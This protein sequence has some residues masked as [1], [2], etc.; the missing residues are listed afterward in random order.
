MPMTFDERAAAVQR[1]TI[2]CHESPR[3]YRVRVVAWILLGYLIIVS[4]LALSLAMSAGVIAGIVAA[5]G[6]ILLKFAWVPIVASWMLARALFVRIDAPIGRRLLPRE[7]P[8]LFAT[9]EEIRVQLGVRRLSG[10]L[11]VNDM[12]AAVVETPRFGGLFGWQRYLLLGAPLLLVQS[13]DE[14]RAILAHELGHLS[15]KHGRVAAWSWRVRVTWSRVLESLDQ[16]RGRLAR[17]LQRLIHWYFDHMMCITLVQ[18]RAQELA[19]DEFAVQMTDA[20][21]AARALARNSVAG[22]LLLQHFWQPLWERAN[23]EP[24]PPASPLSSFLVKRQEVLGQPSDAVFETELARTTAL[25]DTHPS[26]RE[27][28]QRM[29]VPHPDLGAPESFAAEALFGTS[30]GAIVGELDRTWLADAAP[31]WRA[32]HQEV[33]ASRKLLIETEAEDLNSLDDEQRHKRA[34][35]LEEL[36]RSD[37]ALAIYEEIAARNATDARAAFQLGRILVQRGDLAGLPHL[38]RAIE[39]DW[40]AIGASCE[41]A[42]NALREKGMEKEA[43]A[44]AER[45]RQEEHRLAEV[46]SEAGTLSVNDDFAPCA[47]PVD[48]QEKL[49]AQC[50]KAK[51]VGKVWLARKNL[52]G[53]ASVDFLAIRAKM[54]SFAGDTRFRRLLSSLDVPVV[55]FLIENGTLM[56][57]LDRVS[58]ARRFRDR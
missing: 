22:T 14:V 16:R 35:S 56:R 41:V 10:V 42:Y 58:G 47:L 6:W 26:L 49:V 51:W 5:R 46:Q 21:T 39:H 32:R 20:P 18:A 15:G 9:I 43:D 57:R 34:E 33:A 2:A 13:L 23:D 52:P 50:F 38:S 17:G 3:L 19:A 36:G 37:E 54:F 48:V 45:Y 24:E 29:G 7:A 12:N 4:L 8:R 30:L 1:L 44:W 53:S 28:L 25:D 27:R 31:A 55:V 11:L 40:R